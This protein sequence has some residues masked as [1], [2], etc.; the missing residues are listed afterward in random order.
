MSPAPV[1]WRLF[2]AVYP[3][4][5]TA[6][7][8]LAAVREAVGEDAPPH[9][10]TPVDQVHLTVQFVG[11]TPF[12]R[13]DN[14]MES[15][16]RAASGVGPMQLA[17]VRLVTRPARGPVR[18]I[19]AET[20]GPPALLEI[21]RRLVARLARSSRRDPARRFVPHLTLCRFHPPVRRRPLREPLAIPPFPVRALKLM[22]SELLPTGAVHRE[23]WA[24][25]LGERKHGRTPSERG[26]GPGRPT[27]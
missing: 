4:L 16:A 6:R 22:R 17:P 13:T 1:S 2:V 3:P 23:V 8:M 18:L 10:L 7:E 20:D 15:V 25:V 14:V 27:R 11:D 5:E 12:T 19:A 26:A 21:K 9:R 24:V